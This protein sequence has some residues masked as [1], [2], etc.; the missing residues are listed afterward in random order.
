MTVQRKRRKTATPRPDPVELP[1]GQEPS[2]FRARLYGIRAGGPGSSNDHV[3]LL[4][5]IPALLDRLEKAEADVERLEFAR[6]ELEERAGQTQSRFDRQAKTIAGLRE[7]LS[8][9]LFYNSK[10]NREAA[11]V[12]VDESRKPTW[13]PRETDGCPGIP[14]Q[15]F[16]HEVHVGK[17][18]FGQPLEA[19]RVLAEG[20][21]E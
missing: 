20:E 8:D 4:A 11:R 3:Q 17:D 19:R 14:N 9:L 13:P 6:H 7:A 15:M 10:Q 18:C 5:A 12:A 16:C 2:W 21:D 1:A